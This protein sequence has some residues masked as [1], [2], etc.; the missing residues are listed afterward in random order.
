MSD[1]ADMIEAAHNGLEDALSYI[2]S[3]GHE[4]RGV[5][6]VV[7]HTNPETR[8]EECRH[9]IIHREGE[10]IP[11][12]GCVEVLK[13]RVLEKIACEHEPDKVVE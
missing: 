13:A 5:A 10:V 12:L 2:E 8:R 9:L 7:H 3:A 4:V 1:G 6:F 11:L